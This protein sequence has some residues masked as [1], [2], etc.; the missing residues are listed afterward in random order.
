MTNEQYEKIA[1][2]WIVNAGLFS[3]DYLSIGTLNENGFIRKTDENGK[4][5]SYPTVMTV[6]FQHKPI[7]GIEIGGVAP[8][9]VVDV[10]LDGK[11]LSATKIQR[12]F[13]PLMKYPIISV[14]RALEELV[15]GNGTIYN[16]YDL[17]LNGIVNN[18]KLVYYNMEV[19]ANAKV[20]LPVYVVS[21]T[22]ESGDFTAVTYALDGKYLRYL[23]PV[24]TGAGKN[25]PVRTD[26]VE[27]EEERRK[28][29]EEELKK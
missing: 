21:G 23:N 16:V 17:N 11:V 27:N 29:I 20:L 1:Y 25:E 5:V 15:K 19:T 22:C 28:A 7:E 6:Q 10:G 8:R 2:D 24:V 26:E 12:S 9:F 18:V 3:D 13:K 4:E 14:D